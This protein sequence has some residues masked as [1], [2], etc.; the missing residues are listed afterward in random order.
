MNH[1]VVMT[2]YK[3]VEQINRFINLAPKNFDFYVHLDKK[4]TIDK[5]ALSARAK[6][7][8][9]YNKF[10]G[11]RRAFEGFFISFERGLFKW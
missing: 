2:A 9:E 11:G 4:S 1:C 10:R 8:S 3:D 7:F 6:V 5:S